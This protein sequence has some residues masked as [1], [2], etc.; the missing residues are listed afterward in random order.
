MHWNCRGLGSPEAVN[1]LRC[2]VINKNPQVVFLQEIKLHQHEMERITR[3]LKFSNCLVVGCEGQGRKGGGVLMWKS[4][5]SLSIESS[6]NHIDVRITLSDQNTWRF[7]S[8]YGHPEE[9][10]ISKT[11]ELLRMLYKDE[12]D[13]WLCGGDLNLML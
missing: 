1:A 4:E 8:I 13:P 10:N 2:I 3:N 7:T 11:G 12:N 6:Q 9:S 5:W